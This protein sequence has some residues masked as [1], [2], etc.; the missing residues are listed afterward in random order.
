[1][2]AR[3]TAIPFT[4]DD[5]DAVAE[6]YCGDEPWAEYV[7]DWIKGAPNGVIEA[8]DMGTAVWLYLDDNNDIVGYGSLGVTE[9]YYPDPY[10]G[11]KVSLSVIPAYAIQSRFHKQPPGDWSQHYASE[12]LNDLINEA[13]RRCMQDSSFAA[14]LCLF[15]DE[16]NARAIRHYENHGFKKYAKPIKGRGQRMVLNLPVVTAHQVTS[17]DDSSDGGQ[18]KQ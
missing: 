14:L 12:I 11:E 15:V 7:A 18:A 5:L 10:K 1:M 2:D 17:Q 6:F 13:I 3:L 9:W 8:L 16:R 4:K